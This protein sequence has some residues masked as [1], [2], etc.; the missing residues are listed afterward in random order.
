MKFLKLSWWAYLAA[1]LG[2]LVGAVAF[3]TPS[4]KAQGGVKVTIEVVKDIRDRATIQAEGSQIVG[5]SCANNTSGM[6]NKCWVA[7]VK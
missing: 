1:A 3:H 5:F 6:G 2:L 7:S 4:L